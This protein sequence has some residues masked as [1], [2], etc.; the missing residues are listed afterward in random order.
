MA[1]YILTAVGGK[2]RAQVRVKHN[3]KVVRT[4]TRTFQRRTAAESW[5]K[6][7]VLELE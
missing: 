2:H 7:R 5:A 3:G 6:R 1:Y 4:E